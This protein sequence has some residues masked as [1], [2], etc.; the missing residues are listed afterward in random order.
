MKTK[1]VFG[2]LNYVV[3]LKEELN[4]IQKASFSKLKKKK[5]VQISLS[6]IK[7]YLFSRCIFRTYHMPYTTYLKYS[8]KMCKN[9]CPCKVTFYWR[10]EDI[11]IY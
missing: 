7:I 2:P 9:R 4:E 1:K 3:Y 11:I 10:K 6:P 5:A 8:R